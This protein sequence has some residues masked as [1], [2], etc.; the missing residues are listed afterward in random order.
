MGPPH[1]HRRRPI[2]SRDTVV[3]S[4]AKQIIQL[5]QQSRCPPSTRLAPDLVSSA[6]DRKGSIVAETYLEADVRFSIAPHQKRSVSLLANLNNS[7]RVQSAGQVQIRCSIYRPRDRSG[8]PSPQSV[9]LDK[10]AGRR[11]IRSR[12]AAGAN[13][14]PRFQAHEHNRS[15]RDSEGSSCRFA[16]RVLRG[17][18]TGSP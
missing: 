5:A 18:N 9:A 12:L 3:P 15:R 10:Y 6:N 1:R 7:R 17:A 13:F 8:G 16:C 4:P 11:S 14:L 2:D